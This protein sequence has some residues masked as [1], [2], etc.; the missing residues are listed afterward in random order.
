MLGCILTAA[1]YLEGYPKKDF[2]WRFT[3][4]RSKPFDKRMVTIS[5]LHDFFDLLNPTMET[6][7][8][9]YKNLMIN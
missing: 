4:P 9:D 3:D 8:S 7:L 1:C 5:S 6:M 2:P